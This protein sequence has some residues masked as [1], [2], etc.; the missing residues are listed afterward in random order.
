MGALL[1]T[2]ARPTGIYTVCRR[3]GRAEPLGWG[4]HGQ[5]RQFIIFLKQVIVA[6]A[7]VVI[8]FSTG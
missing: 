4:F 6:L 5:F 8:G 2:D 7:G 3:A 1:F